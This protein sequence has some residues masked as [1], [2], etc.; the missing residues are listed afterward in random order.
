LF[1][2]VGY[3]SMKKEQYI[4][5]YSIV[6]VLFSFNETIFSAYK[7]KSLVLVSKR[8][9]KVRLKD[10]YSIQITKK[11]QIIK[12]RKKKEIKI[13]L[14]GYELVSYD[15][16]LS[17]LNK[18]EKP[19]T[20]EK[21]K[22]KLLNTN[23]W[24]K[25]HLTLEK[26]LQVLKVAI[27]LKNNLLIDSLGAFWAEQ[28]KIQPSLVHE[29]LTKESSAIVGSCLMQKI[30]IQKLFN[31]L[32]PFQFPKFGECNFDEEL[33]I[34]T[35]SQGSLLGIQ[36]K[37]GSEYFLEVYSPEKR[38]AYQLTEK[39]VPS[40]IA[41]SKKKN[42][43]AFDAKCNEDK[44]SSIYI[45]NT[46]TDL[47]VQKLV[48]NYTSKIKDL[49]FNS[50]GERLAV[51]TKNYVDIRD[52]NT[53]KQ[54][55]R[56][57]FKDT[58]EAYDYIGSLFDK[59][60]KNVISVFKRGSGL[61]FVSENKD[62]HN[63]IFVD[64]RNELSLCAC[65][66]LDQEAKTIYA[67]FYHDFLIHVHQYRKVILY[68]YNINTQEERYSILPL[69]EPLKRFAIDSTGNYL[70]GAFK[71][72]KSKSRWY[73]IDRKNN[74]VLF[75]FKDQDA[76]NSYPIAGYDK[77]LFFVQRKRACVRLCIAISNNS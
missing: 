5:F 59:K 60:N 47:C 30:N 48:P 7:K 45:W 29:H 50:S 15:S 22:K 77:G 32:Y 40:V 49:L 68:E 35:H 34:C 44:A 27:C 39:Q 1:C 36:K 53:G 14:N 63:S 62:K 2:V 24:K 9:S 13:P 73:L 10:S 54:L 23:N 72:S 6:F 70:L 3:R 26:I 8:D 17:F 16:F 74:K 71:K 69:T 51:I 76:K 25:T 55:K 20:S 52:S 18:L 64:S 57:K 21:I 33:N 65:V 43:C 42:L 11:S 58:S 12:N 19:E 46:N 31:K 28:C 4:Y 56:W 38:K 67:A 61:K 37:R 41:Y 66:Y 75:R